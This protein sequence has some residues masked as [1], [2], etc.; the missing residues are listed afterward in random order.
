MLVSQIDSAELMTETN[1]SALGN[2]SLVIVKYQKISL[3]SF[4]CTLERDLRVPSDSFICASRMIK[5][6]QME[7]A[8]FN[9]NTQIRKKALL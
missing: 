4:P 9:M 7:H 8:Q 6:L 2:R 5:L 3:F 1:C